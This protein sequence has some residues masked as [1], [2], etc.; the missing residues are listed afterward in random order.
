[1]NQNKAQ[2]NQVFMFI[3]AL[4]IIGAIALIGVRSIG[5]IMEDKCTTDFVIFRDKLTETISTNNDYGSVNY[6]RLST[7][8]KYHTLCMVDA[9]IIENPE[10]FTGTNFPG[11]FIITQSVQDGVEAN[12]F[13]IGQDNEVRELGFIRQLQLEDAQNA[14]CIRVKGGAFN[15]LLK[16]Q[17]RT[18]LVSEKKNDI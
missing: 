1:M 18:T 16:G 3:I 17:G 7:P 8:C 9:T 4:F 2:I 11:S 12:A 13:L 15:L 6:E 5:G 14:T 10:E